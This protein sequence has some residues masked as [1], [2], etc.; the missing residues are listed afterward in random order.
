MKFITVF[1]FVL[2]FHIY[3]EIRSKDHDYNPSKTVAIIESEKTSNLEEFSNKVTEYNLE[4]VD[5]LCYGFSIVLGDD[6]VESL[7]ETFVSKHKN[8]AE[9]EFYA[10]A[11]FDIRCPNSGK[12]FID[13]M[14][15]KNAPNLVSLLSRKDVSYPIDEPRKYNDQD[16]MCLI[17]L[18]R[19][20]K[21]HYINKKWT[22]YYIDLLKIFKNLGAN[23]SPKCTTR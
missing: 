13:L 22:G 5:N 10:K 15:D 3:A 9:E 23:S 8:M 7:V 12:H 17:Q 6:H 16:K 11:I 14:L 4:A 20:Y 19:T 21:G 2:H 1:L 18:L